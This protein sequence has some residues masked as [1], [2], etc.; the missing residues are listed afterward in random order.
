MKKLFLLLL[1]SAIPAL[2]AETPFPETPSV[3]GKVNVSDFLNVRLGPGLRHPVTGRLKADQEVEILRIAENWL[4]I[5]APETLKI[6]VSEARIDA[7]GKLTGELNMRSRMDVTAPSYG[8]LGTGS[9]VKR[10]PERRNGWVRIVPP[11]NLKVYVAA[12]CVTFDR[13]KFNEKG[14]P[15][16]TGETVKAEEAKAETNAAPAPEAKAETNAAPAPEAKAEAKS[17]TPVAPAPEVKAETQAVPVKVEV[18]EVKP[19]AEITLA[20]VVVKW[21]FAKTPETALAFLDSPDGK[22]QAFVT[23]STPELQEQL[24][25]SA[26]SGKRITVKGSYTAGKMPPVFN[27]VSIDI[28]Q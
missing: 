8:L 24:T 11:A 26:D 12:I 13:S 16:G 2:W 17:E 28:N 25:K 4:E 23:G 20:G 9:I 7:E 21:K 19:A 5:K 10:L 6:Y 3:K 1:A 15:Q 14:L 18:T 22:N 27:V